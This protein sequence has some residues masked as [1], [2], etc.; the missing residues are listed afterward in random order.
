VTV[1]SITAPDR[2]SHGGQ[3]A[4]LLVSL[5]ALSSP[6]H[7]QLVELDFALPGD[8]WVTRDTVN[9][10]DWIDLTVT[11]GWSVNDALASGYV[12][13]FGYHVATAAE[14][15]SLFE[16][17]GLSPSRFTI[18]Q[19]AQESVAYSA[20]IPPN[21]PVPPTVYTSE[22][23][24]AFQTLGPLLGY[25]AQVS[26]SILTVDAMNGFFSDDP[27]IDWVGLSD[28]RYTATPRGSDWTLKY[29]VDAAG[30]DSST[31]ASNTGVFLVRASQDPPGC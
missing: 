15:D 22:A 10:L 4:L 21:P 12:T 1:R 24:T 18:T 6:G 2:R 27:L 8:G 23:L 5:L 19:T 14:V 26:I 17:A 11:D 25:T 20:G 29:D 30:V 9:N 13:I 28:N 3:L 16:T 31:S 7:A